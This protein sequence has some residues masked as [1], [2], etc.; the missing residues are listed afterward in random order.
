MDKKKYLGQAFVIEKEIRAKKEQIEKLESL[1]I[2][3]SPTFSDLKLSG[4]VSDKEELKCSILDLKEILVKDIGRL[5]YVK[6]DIIK[7]INIV[8]DSLFRT[9]LIEKYINL[10]NFEEIA[11]ELNYSDR[12][13]IRLHNKALDCIVIGD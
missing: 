9:I 8:E 11:G 4:G 2:Y 7:K 1:L 10:K 3:T 5:V 12:Q 13:V 6:H